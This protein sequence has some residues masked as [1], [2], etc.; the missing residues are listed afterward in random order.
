MKLTLL[1]RQNL[2]PRPTYTLPPDV[3][4]RELQFQLSSNTGLWA[5]DLETRGVDASDPDT[6][7]V[8]IGLADEL[9][10]LY[11]DLRT[12]ST[13]CMTWLIGWIGTQRFIAFNVLFDAAFLQKLTGSWPQIEGD[14]YALYKQLSSEG[15]PGQKWNL[16]SFELNVLG[17]PTTNKTALDAALKERNWT[18]ADMWQLPVEIIG[19]Y[20]AIDADAAWQGWIYLNEVCNTKLPQED[21]PD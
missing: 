8:G 6:F 19:P 18:K 11:I 20:C 16:E 12:L 15:H 2:A 17:W 4:L 21:I 1:E 9:R 14:V 7:V 5:I 3:A 10:C 13:A